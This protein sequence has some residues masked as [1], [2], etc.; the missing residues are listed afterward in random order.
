MTLLFFHS[1]YFSFNSRGMLSEFPQTHFWAWVT[2]E[3]SSFGSEPSSPSFETFATPISFLVCVQS[4]ALGRLRVVE[5]GRFVLGIAQAKTHQLNDIEL[6]RA[7]VCFKLTTIIQ[8]VKQVIK[9]L[10]GN[11]VLVILNLV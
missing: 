8:V 1:L 3:G 10:N 4:A 7:L 2:D 11:H 9:C 5:A 6:K